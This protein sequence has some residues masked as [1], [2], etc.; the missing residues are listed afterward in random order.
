MRQQASTEPPRGPGLGTRSEAPPRAGLR[1]SGDGPAS[2]RP[3]VWL[4]SQARPV[5]DT[6]AGAVGLSVAGGLLVLLQAYLLAGV[7]DAVIFGQAPLHA[8][9]PALTGLLAVY[10]G[11][12]AALWT[13]E[14]MAFAA[15]A[16][17]K[18]SLRERLLKRLDELG[19]AWQRMQQ[20]GDLVT[21]VVE[22]VD[23]LD[24][25]FARYLPQMGAAALVPLSMLVFVVPRDW[26]SAG[27]FLLTV[28]LIPVFMVLIGKGAERLN[29]RQWLQLRRLAARFLD[30]IQGLTTLRLLNAS[31]RE[32]EVVARLSDEYR[33]TTMGVLRVAFLSALSLELLATLSIAVVAVFIGFR[34]YG[35]FDWAPI[36]F[37]TGLFVLLLAPEIYLPLRELGARYHARM[38]AIGATGGVLDILEA[39]RPV[40]GDGGAA[41]PEGPFRIRVEGV[42]Y[43]YP[44]GRAALRGVDL[45]VEPGKLLALIGSSGAGKSTLAQLLLG[46][47]APDQGAVQVDGRD[48]AD[49][50]ARSWRAAVAWVPQRPQ[51]LYGTLS[52]NLLLARPEATIGQMWT[53]LEQAGADQFVAALPNGLQT[54]VGER[55]VGLSG[56]ELQR[57]ALAR[58]FLRDARL[59]VLDEPTAHLDAPATS[60]ILATLR[61]LKAGRLVIVIAH[62][63]ATAAAADV[64]AVLED[65]RV[66]ETGTPGQLAALSSRYAAL[67]Q[68]YEGPW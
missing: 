54:V 67:V 58:A 16:E 35:A 11:R 13:A 5:R 52:E 27:V 48:L 12:F 32:I 3:E 55:G 24:G 65:G 49:I 38:E 17:V 42:H 15:A 56:G 2:R 51:L 41:L 19:P 45:R 14:Q 25:Y 61:G 47:L 53:A 63:L 62:R 18:R 66:V 60:G 1:S 6:L 7:A 68:P 10:V 4:R 34:L 50:D 46:F 8:V 59:V 29:Q 26:F 33:R 30:A 37:R 43:A 9:S 36:D 40:A 57:L 28:P 64:V 20:S 21:S 31:R 22:G 44:D 39:P 23:A